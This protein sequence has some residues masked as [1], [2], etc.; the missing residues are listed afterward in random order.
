[1]RGVKKMSKRRRQVKVKVQKVIDVYAK[2]KK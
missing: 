2:K 1:M